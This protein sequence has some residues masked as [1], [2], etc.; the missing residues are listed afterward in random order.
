MII[1][2][3]DKDLALKSKK[4]IKTIE[5]IHGNKNNKNYDELVKNDNMKPLHYGASIK[6]ISTVSIMI[7]NVIYLVQYNIFTGEIVNITNTLTYTEAPM[8]IKNISVIKE[9]LNRI[10]VGTNLE[11]LFSSLTS[12]NEKNS[13][14]QKDSKSSIFEANIYILR[15]LLDKYNKDKYELNKLYNLICNYFFSIYEFI[16]E[17]VQEYFDKLNYFS[18]NKRGNQRKR[19]INR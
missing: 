11:Y 9:L 7:N 17:E 8:D 15:L 3:Q 13:E 14:L 10:Y 5:Y 12:S 6:E 4:I 2:E 18:E 19:F 16:P 1:T